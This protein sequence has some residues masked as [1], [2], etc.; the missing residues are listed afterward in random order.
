MRALSWGEYF[1][2]DLSDYLVSEH[3]SLIC[4]L[5]FCMGYEKTFWVFVVVYYIYTCQFVCL[6]FFCGYAFFFSNEPKRKPLASLYVFGF[7]SY[8]FD[9]LVWLWFSFCLSII[10][11]R[12]LI[13]L[14][15]PDAQNPA[16]HMTI[17]DGGDWLPK[18]TLMPKSM[19]Y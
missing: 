15:L 16:R 10:V 18:D 1:E 7:V 17:R 19:K 14:Q 8:A 6:F 3:Q 13:N 4:G 12:W 9:L 2:L 11:Q 5:F